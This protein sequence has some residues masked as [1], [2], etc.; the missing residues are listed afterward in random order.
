M[1]LSTLA[2]SLLG[3]VAL[4]APSPCSDAPVE[5]A[6]YPFTKI[7]AFGDELSDNGNGSFAHGITGNPA[8]VY[9]F[10][11]TNPLYFSK[12]HTSPLTAQITRH[13]DQWP[14][15]HLL[16]QR[17]TR[18]WAIRSNRL[19]LWR[20]LRRRLLWRNTGSQ[21]HACL[22]SQRTSTNP[23]AR[24][25]HEQQQQQQQQQQRDRWQPSVRHRMGRAKRPQR[26]HRCILARRPAQRLVCR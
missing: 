18:S 10:G 20:L 5:Q 16:S 2:L 3:S 4:A 25:L 1:L 15:S 13:M 7:V 8:T 12:S 6:S 24:Q 9:G 21:L 22:A 11:K 26:A 23:T 14:S 17:P 19:R